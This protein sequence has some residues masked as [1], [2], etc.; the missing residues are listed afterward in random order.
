MEPR[1][2]K[3]CAFRRAFQQKDGGWAAIREGKEQWVEGS[4]HAFPE[5]GSRQLSLTW[6]ELWNLLSRKAGA[7]LCLRPNPFW[8]SAEGSQSSAVQQVHH[9]SHTYGSHI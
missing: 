3:P 2:R 7:F 1:D 5:E 4:I 9:G 8:K 6:K